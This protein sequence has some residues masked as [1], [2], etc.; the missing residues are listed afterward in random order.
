MRV[1]GLDD[2]L[3]NYGHPAPEEDTQ[4]VLREL[5]RKK[6]TITVTLTREQF[7]AL[8][9]AVSSYDNELEQDYPERHA[10]RRALNNGWGAINAAWRERR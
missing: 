8:L 5:K 7:N 6:A 4:T 1:P 3:D 2:H 9:E 10:T